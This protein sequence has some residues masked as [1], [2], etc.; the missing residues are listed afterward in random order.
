MHR[1]DA[2]KKQKI[3]GFWSG[4]SSETML[5]S[6]ISEAGTATLLPPPRR[7]QRF[8]AITG[9]P[10]SLRT[11]RLVRRT[12][13]R[14]PRAGIKTAHQGKRDAL[15]LKGHKIRN[16]GGV[17]RCTPRLHKKGAKRLKFST[18][19]CPHSI[20]RNDRTGDPGRATGNRSWKGGG[21]RR[22]S[23]Q[24]LQ[25]VRREGRRKNTVPADVPPRG[26]PRRR[27]LGEETLAVPLQSYY[28]FKGSLQ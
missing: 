6:V 15:G 13:E 20:H 4:R 23:D 17:I 16:V 12:D 2:R 10:S 28:T 14:G 19:L 8:H 1:T 18:T 7:S 26:L 27:E 22:T 5:V 9:S 3:G 21:C 11:T 25:C 24:D